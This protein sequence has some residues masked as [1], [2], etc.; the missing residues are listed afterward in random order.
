MTMHFML[1]GRR[2]DT[3]YVHATIRGTHPLG[4]LHC[5]FKVKKDVYPVAVKSLRCI[6]IY[7]SLTLSES[8]RQVKHIRLGRLF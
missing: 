1:E 4:P 6:L 2:S 5:F 8:N 7:F 3:L